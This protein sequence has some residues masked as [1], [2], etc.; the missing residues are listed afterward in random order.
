MLGLLVVFACT[1]TSG[2]NSVR[3]VILTRNS[4]NKISVDGLFGLLLLFAAKLAA[5]RRTY[6]ARLETV[7]KLAGF[8]SP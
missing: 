5:G 6:N 7:P 1:S 8:V 4:G 3:M 2:A